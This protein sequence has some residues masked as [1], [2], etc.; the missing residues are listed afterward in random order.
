MYR[1]CPISI[2]FVAPP[3]AAF[4]SCPPALA[5]CRATLPSPVPTHPHPSPSF[6]CSIAETL[7]APPAFVVIL[8]IGIISSVLLNLYWSF[9][10]TKGMVKHVLHFDVRSKQPKGGKKGRRK[11]TEATASQSD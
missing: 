4:L 5:D 3:H 11:Q 1:L 6:L 2:A 8:F 7:A 9:F 10:V